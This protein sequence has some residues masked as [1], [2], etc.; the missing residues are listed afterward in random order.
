MGSNPAIPTTAL[1]LRREGRFFFEM[2]CHVYVLR[3]ESSGRL[4]VGH[5]ADL[6]RRLDEHNAGH[7]LSTRGRGPWTRVA[8]KA[9]AKRS[10]AVRAERALKALKSPARVLETVASW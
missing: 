8:S 3:S 7:S 1:L 2:L 10:D 9:F 4:Y 6:D 5:T